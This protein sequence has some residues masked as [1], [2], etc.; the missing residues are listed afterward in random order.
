[1]SNNLKIASPWSQLAIFL[2]ILG[3]CYVLAGIV[4]IVLPGFHI[5]G[6]N[7]PGMLKLAQT[8]GSIITFGL[9]AIF[10]ARMTFADRPLYYLGFRPSVNNSFYIVAVFLLLVSFPLEIGLGMLNKQVSLPHWAVQMEQENDR[11]VET[12]LQVKTPMDL[13]INLLV[14][15]VIPAIFEE[16]CFRGALQ[17]ILI[18]AL[19]NP[20][21]GIVVTAILFSLLHFQLQGFL[22]RMFLGILLGAAY[23]YSGSLWT[24]ILAHGFFNGVQVVLASQYPKAINEN[25]SV[26]WSLVGISLIIVVSLLVYMRRRSTITYAQVYQP[27]GPGSD[28]RGSHGV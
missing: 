19:K 5:K 18:H 2:A 28:I 16:I 1:M 3:G 26:P 8:L 6:P 25:P 21:A 13:Y 22:P 27:E 4:I 10:Y 24:T 9:P 23:W 7:S 20:W 12:L 15:A 14:V 17:R 11:Q